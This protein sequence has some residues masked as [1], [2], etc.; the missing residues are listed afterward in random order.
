M[1]VNRRHDRAWRGG[2]R[3]QGRRPRA[4]MVLTTMDKVPLHSLSPSPATPIVPS[5]LRA[6]WS[7]MS[8]SCRA[9]LSTAQLAVS[10]RPTCPILKP[11]QTPGF[12][13]MLFHPIPCWS[14]LRPAQKSLAR[15]L[16][17]AVMSVVA[18]IGWTTVAPGAATTRDGL[19]T[20][21]SF[22]SSS[23]STTHSDPVGEA[24]L[25]ECRNMVQAE[26]RGDG[27][28]GV[29]RRFGFPNRA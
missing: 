24:D 1:S 2:R 10:C 28:G 18:G 19:A 7:T 20:P 25:V 15:Y 21:A 13:A 29:Q 6:T 3:G 8:C 11:G 17:L 16:A 12:W 22:S 5:C 23:S 14:G 4:R 26:R 27:S 9:G